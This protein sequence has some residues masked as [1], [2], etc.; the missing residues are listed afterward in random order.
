MAWMEMVAKWTNL[1]AG[2]TFSSWLQIILK[3]SQ[4]RVEYEILRNMQFYV[5]QLA[6]NHF[7]VF[8]VSR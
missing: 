5:F 4:C 7:K 6:P 8:T 2:L 3:Y 1:N